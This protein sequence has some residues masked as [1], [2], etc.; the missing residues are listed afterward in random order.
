MQD[1]QELNTDI[2]TKH[3]QMTHIQLNAAV[4]HQ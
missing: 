3:Q 1:I 2:T 4:S